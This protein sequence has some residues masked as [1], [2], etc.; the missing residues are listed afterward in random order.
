[1]RKHRLAAFSVGLVVLAEGVPLRAAELGETRMYECPRTAVPPVIDGRLD[2]ACWQ[3]APVT[4]QFTLTLNRQGEA[5]TE[6]TSARLLYDA[7]FLYMGITCAEAH[8]EALKVTVTTRD[9]VSV[10]GDDAIE[11]FFQ[12]DPP[13]GAY[14]QLAA[15]SIAAQYDGQAFDGSWDADWQAEAHVGQ[16]AWTLECA[17]RLSSL[18]RLPAAG[19]AWGFNLNREYR[20]GEYQ[21]WSNTFG[22]FHNPGRFGHL[23][24][25]GPLACLKRVDL[26]EAGRC[27]LETL[28]Q[29]SAL[30][31]DHA[32]FMAGLNRLAPDVQA[33]LRVTVD[34]ALRPL[35]EW[36]A[37]LGNRETLSLDE[38]KE[39]DRR[40]KAARKGVEDAVWELRFR[41][42][43]LD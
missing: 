27:A 24:F 14:F 35:E 4:G 40:L 17:I 41:L 19:E 33:R 36:E 3:Q 23:I 22:G 39:F 11:M 43:L 34:A 18:G 25:G 31:H 12:P 15:N 28:R 13:D 8:P 5:P 1:M 10:C 16:D 9:N 37:G 42:L 20:A 6:P 29:E 38:W 21:C 7:Q 26:I 2:E 32:E 30:R